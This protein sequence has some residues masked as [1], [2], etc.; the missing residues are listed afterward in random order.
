VPFEGNLKLVSLE[1]VL[2][3]IDV[4]H[5]TGVLTISDPRGERRVAFTAGKLT[6]F[7]PIPGE[8][9]PVPDALAAKKLIARD[10]VEKV[11]SS[12]GWKRMNLRRALE[13]RGLVKEQDYAQAVRDEVIVPHILELFANRERQFRFDEKP[14]EATPSRR[15]RWDEDQLAAELRIMIGPLVLECVRRLDELPY[16]ERPTPP[17]VRPAQPEG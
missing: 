6:A 16:D 9:R 12:L 4:N 3:N 15:D 10:D 7:L 17:P 13:Y 8:E 2:R 11:R 1:S 5:L 14:L